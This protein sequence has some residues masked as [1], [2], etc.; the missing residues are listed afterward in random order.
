MERRDLCCVGVGRRKDE[1]RSGCNMN[2]GSAPA[3]GTISKVPVSLAGTP[4]L[5][6][7]GEA[8]RHEP[9]PVL[10]R[11]MN[12]MNQ[13]IDHLDHG[14]VIGRTVWF[15][16]PLQQAALLRSETRLPG[17]IVGAVVGFER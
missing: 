9:I 16:D 12:Q 7:P 2:H 8:Q 15:R 11:P 17:R 6:G 14:R 3:F 13:A 1:P 5:V 4:L 10:H